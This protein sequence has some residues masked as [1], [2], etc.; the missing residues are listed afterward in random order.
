MCSKAIAIKIKP[1]GS[2]PL[3]CVELPGCFLRSAHARALPCACHPLCLRVTFAAPLLRFN[4]SWQNSSVQ[5][6]SA[7][8]IWILIIGGAGIVLGAPGWVAAASPSAA[9]GV[10]AGGRA[11]PLQAHRTR[12]LAAL[13]R[14]WATRNLVSPCSCP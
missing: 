5:S 6:T 12:V 1:A 3:L 4:C 8:P 7:V 14:G 11:V 10:P 2:V 9:R 13:L